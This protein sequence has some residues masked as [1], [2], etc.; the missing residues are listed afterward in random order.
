MGDVV[1]PTG[2]ADMEIIN[3]LGCHYCLKKQP[4][5]SI[6]MLSQE[7]EGTQSYPIV[8]VEV[9]SSHESLH[10]LLSECA[11]WLNAH[12]DVQYVIAVKF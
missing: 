11:A 10:I 8:V 9:A 4:D 5:A 2:A 12:T 3:E 1:S 7:L 6:S